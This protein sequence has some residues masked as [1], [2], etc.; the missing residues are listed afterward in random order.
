[1]KIR[2]TFV[3][4]LSAAVALVASVVLAK[5]VAPEEQVPVDVRRTTFVVKNTDAA[6]ALYRDALG[7]KVVYDQM[8]ES[9]SPEQPETFRQTRLVLMRA[10]DDFIGALGLLEYVR[11]RKPEHQDHFETPVP[12]DPIVIINAQNLDEVWAK[13]KAVPGV[14]IHSEPHLVEYPKPGGGVIRVMMSMI[15][16]PNN[17]WIEINKILDAPAGREE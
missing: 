14:T 3:Y 10:N 7:M 11:P 15:R 16:D 8:L 6:L 13:V 4:G 1:M 5:P 17:Y 9:G 2:R 12:G